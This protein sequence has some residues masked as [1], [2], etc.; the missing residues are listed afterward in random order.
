MNNAKIDPIYKGNW[1]LDYIQNEPYI[2]INAE[3]DI[4][5][6][7]IE[8]ANPIDKNTCVRV[9]FAENYYVDLP[10]LVLSEPESLLTSS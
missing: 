7:I 9:V 4:F 5:V 6:P 8:N 3:G 10:I 2:V 1:Y